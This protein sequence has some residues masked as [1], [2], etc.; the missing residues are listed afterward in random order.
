MESEKIPKS[1]FRKNIY[2]ADRFFS[3][4]KPKHN[5]A[6]S[7]FADFLTEDFPR[8]LILDIFKNVHFQKVDPFCFPILEKWG[9]TDPPFFI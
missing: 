2:A 4:L 7:I 6:T 9:K 1:F 5:G 8:I 3:V